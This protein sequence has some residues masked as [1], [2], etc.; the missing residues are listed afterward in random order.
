MFPIP[1][2]FLYGLFAGQRN[3]ALQKLA[4]HGGRI[5]QEGFGLIGPWTF[6]VFGGIEKVNKQFDAT[7]V[8][9]GTTATFAEAP[10][11]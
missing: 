7:R 4:E 9:F 8:Q 3:I 10:C 2:T 1:V 11:S 6:G 5:A